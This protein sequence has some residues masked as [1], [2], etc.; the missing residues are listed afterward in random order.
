HLHDPVIG[1][2]HVDLAGARRV[3]VSR[4]VYA[5]SGI[6]YGK[7]LIGVALAHQKRGVQQL[8]SQLH[9]AGGAGFAVD[10]RSGGL[11]VDLRGS[12]TNA[13]LEVHVD[14]VI[15]VKRYTLPLLKIKTLPF[16]AYTIITGVQIGDVEHAADRRQIAASKTRVFVYGRYRGFGDRRST[17]I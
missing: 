10:D 9:K 8:C 15:G 7:A 13:E 3:V 5:N 14:D 11:D 6:V 12:G 17:R 4:I 16:D 2:I 1:P